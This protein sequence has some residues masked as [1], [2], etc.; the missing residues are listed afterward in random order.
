MPVVVLAG[1]LPFQPYCRVLT[2]V[3]SAGGAD[4]VNWVSEDLLVGWRPLAGGVRGRGEV[5]WPGVTSSPA[6]GLS[7]CGME[8]PRGHPLC[9]FL[10][11]G[12]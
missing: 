2:S 9:L 7:W 8:L 10:L 4:G 1:G 3:V 5:G 11:L 12:L 6:A